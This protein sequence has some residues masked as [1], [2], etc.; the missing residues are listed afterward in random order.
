[1]VR[2]PTRKKNVDH[3]LI[4]RQVDYQGYIWRVSAARRRDSQGEAWLIL[5][6][7][8]TV[9]VRAGPFTLREGRSTEPP[10]IELEHGV[11]VEG[12]VLQANGAP[13]PRARILVT[14]HGSVPQIFADEAGKFALPPLPYGTYTLQA[15][16]RNAS[17]ALESPAQELELGAGQSVPT[18]DLRFD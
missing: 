7:K 15:Q 17:G 5:R 3:H 16:A 8:S 6:G 14:G 13:M 10:A 1:M 4:G 2:K 18:V 12:R 9:P 11:R